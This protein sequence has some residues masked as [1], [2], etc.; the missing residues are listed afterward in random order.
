MGQNAFLLDF[1]FVLHIDNAIATNYDADCC[2]EKDMLPSRQ[3][4]LDRCVTHCIFH[5][6]KVAE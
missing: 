1:L 2:P 4:D 5:A 3:V 6:F